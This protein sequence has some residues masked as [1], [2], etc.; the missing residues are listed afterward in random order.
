MGVQVPANEVAERAE[1][2]R[3]ALEADGG[4]ELVA[5]DR[6]RRRSRSP[7]ST[8]R[9]C[10]AFL[11]DAWAD[12][13]RAGHPARFLAPETI[14]I[15]AVSEGMSDGRRGASR[16][17]HRRAAR[18]TGRSTRP[19]RI[20]AGTYAA[21]RAAVDVALT[22]VD[23]VLGGDDGGLRAVPA[24]RAP[25][26]A[27]DVRRLL[28]LQQRR[29]RRARRSPARTG[30]RVAIL[31]VDYH[32]GNGTEQIFWRRGDVLYVSLHAHPDRQYPYFLG[33]ADE[34]GEGEGA[35]ANLNMP[36][37]AGRP[38]S[39]YLAALD[40][41]LDA[42]RGPRRAPCVVVSL[43]FDT[44]GQDPIGD[45]ALTT[46]GLP[47]DGRRVAALGRRLVILQEGGYHLPDARRRTPGPG[48][49]APRAGRST[50]CRPRGSTPAGRAPD[51][52]PSARGVRSAA[53]TESTDTRDLPDH[54][55]ELVEEI[56]TEIGDG[57]RAGRRSGR[58]RVRRNGR[59]EAAV[60]EI[61]RR[62]R[63]GPRP[64]GPRR[65]AGPR[66]SDV[67]RADRRLPRR[68]RAPDQRRDLRRRL[69]RDGGRQ[70]HPVLL[71]VRAPPAAVL[72]Q[73]RTSPTSPRDGSSGC[74]RS[75]G[76]SRCTP[77]GSRSRSG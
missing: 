54:V 25:R 22:T 32:H 46:D 77:A 9:A 64:R 16:A 49:A 1:R 62:D 63:R 47:R 52:R 36:L 56:E 75:R 55:R 30:E 76:S 59:V 73:R 74:R 37:P 14:A 17:A 24:A 4:F 13:R 11:D 39:G 53:M 8:T 40:R 15:G 34:V 71:A 28:L 51:R 65:H 19:P 60:R 33:W 43:G 42:D 35:G 5:P 27:L 41:A 38:T 3:A 26:R 23:L 10:C 2:I 6:A 66:P 57:R 44:Y 72:R 50:R 68:P 29:D 21:A 7:R 18:A 45:F 58:P 69:L 31:D 61:L 67:R 20:V 48:C 70:G 12:A